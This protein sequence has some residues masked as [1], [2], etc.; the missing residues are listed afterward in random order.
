MSR[1]PERSSCRVGQISNNTYVPFKCL[2][3]CFGPG[4][5]QRLAPKTSFKIMLV[6][7]EFSNHIELLKTL[8]IMSRKFYL[9]L[10]CMHLSINVFFV[11][12]SSFDL[13]NFKFIELVLHTNALL[14]VKLTKFV[15]LKTSACKY[16]KLTFS[17]IVLLFMQI[18][19][20]SLIL[21]NIQIILFPLRTRR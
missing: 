18:T 20:Q 5:T 10:K 19:L 6:I 16:I 15:Y 4:L 7:Y 17:S 2:L 3:G 13:P 21:E 8:S 9:K 1:T 12:I 11:F 14:C